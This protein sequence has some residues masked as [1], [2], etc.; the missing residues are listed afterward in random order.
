ME[1]NSSMSPIYSRSLLQVGGIQADSWTK[2]AFHERFVHLCGATF[3]SDTIRRAPSDLWYAP[4]CTMFPVNVVIEPRVPCYTNVRSQ[5]ALSAVNARSYCCGKFCEHGNWK[6]YCLVTPPI[7]MEWTEKNSSISCFV[8]RIRILLFHTCI[9]LTET[10]NMFHGHRSRVD[11][12]G[13]GTT[14]IEVQPY[15][16][17]M[18]R[19]SALW[20]TKSV[21]WLMQNTTILAELLHPQRVV[22]RRVF[23]S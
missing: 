16:Q 7:G 14:K 2:R 9:L 19:I 10:I 20:H 12:T 22:W 11:W 17:Q 23:V 8:S 3:I 15:K 4:V 13:K 18:H 21:T 5:S 1:P 6:S